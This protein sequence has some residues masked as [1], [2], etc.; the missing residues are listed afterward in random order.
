MW[1]E[2]DGILARRE[3]HGIC[4]RAGRHACSLIEMTRL[5]STVVPADSELQL[6]NLRQEGYD[7]GVDCFGSFASGRGL[8]CVGTL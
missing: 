8:H 2:G 6:L 7:D 1:N 3:R 5:A 4:G